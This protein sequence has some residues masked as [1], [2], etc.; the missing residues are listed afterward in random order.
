ML[1]LGEEHDAG[2]G[3]DAG[4]AGA[5]GAGD[6]ATVEA[7]GSAFGDGRT[8]LDKE[9]ECYQRCLEVALELGN[10]RVAGD[11]RSNLKRLKKMKSGTASNLGVHLQKLSDE[12]HE[13]IL[14]LRT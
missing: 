14:S 8:Q 12:R 5:V 1:P 11:M 13:K 4:M 2:I 6:A 9:R 7:E 3:F 10:K